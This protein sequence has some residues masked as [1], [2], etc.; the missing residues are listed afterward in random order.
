MKAR[1]NNKVGR[2]QHSITRGSDNVFADLGFSPSD[3]ADLKIKAD[4]TWQIH[5][6]IKELGL[7]QAKAAT[8]LGL[9]QPDVS[10]LMNGRHTGY[11]VDRLLLL[12]NALEIDVDIVIR[13]KI[14]NQ[15]ARRGTVRV[16]ETASA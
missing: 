8:Q 13:P 7:T 10:K 9:S 15:K 3:A 5:H 16:V 14:H 6:R 1:R 2:V 12:L 4:L 11:S